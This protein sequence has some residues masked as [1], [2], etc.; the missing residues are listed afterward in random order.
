MMECADYTEIAVHDGGTRIAS[1]LYY[2]GP[3]N[4]ISIGRDKGWGT[5]NTNIA[6]DLSIGYV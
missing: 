2:D 5:S 3:S 4:K 6:G 1:I